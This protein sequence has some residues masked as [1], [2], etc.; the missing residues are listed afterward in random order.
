MRLWSAP[1]RT[2][3][4]PR[5]ASLVGSGG[6]G[7]V[8]RAPAASCENAAAGNVACSTTSVVSVLSI[9]G[10]PSCPTNIEAKALVFSEAFVTNAWYAMLPFLVVGVVVHKL[11]KRLDRGIGNDEQHDE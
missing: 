11:V 1:G 2:H 8:V 6:G 3:L 10:C 4:R 9:L 5:A 7:L